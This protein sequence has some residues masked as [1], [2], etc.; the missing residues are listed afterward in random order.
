M[1]TVIG[2]Y[3]PAD[4]D[5]ECSD[6]ALSQSY[7]DMALHTSGLIFVPDLPHVATA[8]E[9][10]V[11]VPWAALEPFLSEAGQHARQDLEQRR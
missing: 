9:D 2:E 6:F 11:A 4:S 5:E 10:E 1:R 7:F 8:C 3:W